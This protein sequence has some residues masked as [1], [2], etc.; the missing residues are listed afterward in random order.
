MKWK[1]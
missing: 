1:C